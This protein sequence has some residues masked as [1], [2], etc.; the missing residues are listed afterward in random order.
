[1]VNRILFSSPENV[2]FVM[3]SPVDEIG[4]TNVD[5]HSTVGHVDGYPSA[6]AGRVRITPA[7]AVVWSVPGQLDSLSFLVSQ[8]RLLEKSYMYLLTV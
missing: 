3:V 5:H 4:L 6:A 8:S 2:Y 1:M 7:P